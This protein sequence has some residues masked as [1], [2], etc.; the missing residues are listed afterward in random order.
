VGDNQNLR[1][2]ILYAQLSPYIT[3]FHLAPYAMSSEVIRIT[4]D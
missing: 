2:N 3:P 1:M 4:L